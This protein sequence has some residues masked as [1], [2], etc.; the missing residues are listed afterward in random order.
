[1]RLS[2]LIESSGAHHAEQNQCPADEDD[3]NTDPVN[4]NGHSALLFRASPAQQ[5]KEHRQSSE[6]SEEQ[7]PD[8][9][10]HVWKVILQVAQF[11]RRRICA[12]LGKGPPDS[13]LELRRMSPSWEGRSST[14]V[15]RIRGRSMKTE[16]PAGCFGS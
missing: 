8:K 9:T 11:Q 10:F 15:G 1:V 6:R 12:A 4:K 7:K 3:R 16:P 5:T 2:M 14:R 13:P